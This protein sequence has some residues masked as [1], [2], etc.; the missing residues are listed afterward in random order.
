M[1][2]LLELAMKLQGKPFLIFNY[3]FTPSFALI[4]LNLWHS[5]A[6]LSR[7]ISQSA[8]RELLFTLVALSRTLPHISSQLIIIIEP[9]FFSFPAAVDS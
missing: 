6:Q 7:D 8:V 5:L 3:A 1:Q 9:S 2:L 4:R